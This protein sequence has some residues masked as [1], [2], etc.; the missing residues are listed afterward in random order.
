MLRKWIPIQWAVGVEAGTPVN[1]VW[2]NESDDPITVYGPGV[3]PDDAGYPCIAGSSV[4]AYAAELTH[5]PAIDP[6][7]LRQCNDGETPNPPTDLSHLKGVP[8]GDWKGLSCDTL[9]IDDYLSLRRGYMRFGVWGTV[10]AGKW[11]IDNLSTFQSGMWP[12]NV[13][14]NMPA[15]SYSATLQRLI[16]SDFPNLIGYSFNVGGISYGVYHQAFGGGIYWLTVLRNGIAMWFGG[17]TA[18]GGFSGRTTWDGVTVRVYVDGPEVYS[19]PNTGGKDGHLYFDS[20]HTIG[21]GGNSSA[22]YS[23]TELR[24]AASGGDLFYFPIAGVSC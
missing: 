10:V 18:L 13:P 21:G 23:N 15:G 2:R 16:V 4:K 5:N 24:D 14:L 6:A 12:D 1:R 17:T 22:E 3:V 20:N 11:R 9:A 7:F 19:D 8:L